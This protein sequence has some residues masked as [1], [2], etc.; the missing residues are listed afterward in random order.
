M[1]CISG[2]LPAEWGSSVALQLL[3]TGC[4]GGMHKDVHKHSGTTSCLRNT[5][6]RLTRKQ[7]L[8]FSIADPGQKLK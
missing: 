1:S 5:K 6:T 4:T 8:C 3:L 7:V 2:T